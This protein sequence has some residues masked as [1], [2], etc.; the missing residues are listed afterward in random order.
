M[1]PAAKDKVHYDCSVCLWSNLKPVKN[2]HW[3]NN[4]S[5]HEKLKKQFTISLVKAYHTL[6]FPIYYDL[7]N[8]SV[9]LA[10]DKHNCAHNSE[11]LPK[12]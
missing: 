10:V 5:G 11:W 2:T 9:S 6:S 1:R 3:N 8:G 12:N 7:R 4:Q